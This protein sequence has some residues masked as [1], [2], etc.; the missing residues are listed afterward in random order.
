MLL[1]FFKERALAR[2]NTSLFRTNVEQLRCIITSFNW[3]VPNMIE[4]HYAV[5]ALLMMFIFFYEFGGMGQG[6]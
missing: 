4:K 5:T 2:V 1:L 3:E 6:F